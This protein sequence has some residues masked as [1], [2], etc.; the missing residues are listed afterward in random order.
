[1][2]AV[3]TVQHGAQAGRSFRLGRR[4]LVGRSPHCQIR[5]P[6]SG[7]APRHFLLEEHEE[8][9]LLRDLDS[10]GGTY[11][12]GT[13]VVAERLRDGTTI[14]AGEAVLFYREVKGSWPAEV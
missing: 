10:G 11:V 7:V 2:E 1:M 5:L 12:D 9:F 8:H 13:R 3:L 4:V 14:Y 6:D